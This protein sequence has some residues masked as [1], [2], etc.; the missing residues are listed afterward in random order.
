MYNNVLDSAEY[1][2]RK[3][4]RDGK[5]FNN[6]NAAAMGLAK[7]YQRLHRTDSAAKYAI[8]AYAMNDSMYAHQ[9]TETVE[10]MQAMYDYSRHQEEA[11]KE[12]VKATHR[13]IIIW[14]CIGI[15]DVI[16]SGDF[17]RIKSPC[18][19]TINYDRDMEYAWLVISKDKSSALL[20]TIHDKAVPNNANARVKTY[21]L[22]DSKLYN[23][24]SVAKKINIKNFGDLIN[25]VTPIHIK[26][27][28]MLH[29]TLSKVIHMDCEKEDY[30]AY[31]SV[32]NECGIK[33]HDNYASVGFDDH[34]RYYQDYSSRLY[35]ITE[36]KS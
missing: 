36:K 26:P 15:I 35:I 20:M 23:F 8:Y 32:M 17:Y 13:A 7:L 18:T 22:D 4:L 24:T 6:Q 9:A 12:S 21:Y 14:V 31:G 33:L 34:V 1:Y 2:F 30:T 10:R 19:G 28:S 25:A 11:H 29:N 16:S 27:D 3:E 5:D